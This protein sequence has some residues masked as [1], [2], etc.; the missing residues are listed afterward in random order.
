MCVLSSLVHTGSDGYWCGVTACWDLS[1]YILGCIWPSYYRAQITLV[2]VWLSLSDC[3][4]VGLDVLIWSCVYVQFTVVVV[5]LLCCSDTMWT[6]Q[7]VLLKREKKNDGIAV[8]VSK[9]TILKEMAAKI[10][11]DKPAFLFWPSPGTFR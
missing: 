4:Y 8:Y 1:S 6:V 9:E 7:I 3:L 2:Y 11:Y 5:V 10:E